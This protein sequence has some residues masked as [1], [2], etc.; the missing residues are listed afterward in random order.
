[1][2]QVT[3]YDEVA[4]RALLVGVGVLGAMVV[5][6]LG[7]PGTKMIMDLAE[8]QA[9]ATPVLWLVGPVE[10]VIA[11]LCHTSSRTLVFLGVARRRWPFFWWG[12]L[13]FACLDSIAGF[14]HVS[15]KIGEISMW[16]IE[17]AIAPLAIASIP[18]I[19]WCLGHWPEAAPAQG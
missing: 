7:V 3:E 18:I 11:I 10:R 8:E 14:A 13:L 12:F 9:Q 6:L 1:M 19:R 2:A 4:E 17:L 5:A 16:W 15:G